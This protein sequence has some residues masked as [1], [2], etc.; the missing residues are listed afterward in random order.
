MSNVSIQSDLNFYAIEKVQHILVKFNIFY[1]IH[2]ILVLIALNHNHTTPS[3]QGEID[4]CEESFRSTA[5]SNQKLLESDHCAVMEIKQKLVDLAK[6]TSI[7]ERCERILIKQSMLFLRD[8]EQADAW[9]TEQEVGSFKNL[10]FLSV[11]S[12]HSC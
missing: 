2:Y 4:A 6:K 1:R 9:I 8:T 7:L 5:E 11:A 3:K 10:Q 12:T